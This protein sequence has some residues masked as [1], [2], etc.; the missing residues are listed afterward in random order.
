MDVTDM[1]LG[2]HTVNLAFEEETD[3]LEDLELREAQVDIIIEK[4]EE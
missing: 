1:P 2:S 4:N 3:A